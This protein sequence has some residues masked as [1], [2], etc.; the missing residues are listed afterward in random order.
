MSKEQTIPLSECTYEQYRARPKYHPEPLSLL[1]LTDLPD[2]KP[3]IEENANII[4][5][6]AV[7]VVGTIFWFYTNE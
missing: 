4:L 2:E 6:G 5:L 7:C 3:G 1:N